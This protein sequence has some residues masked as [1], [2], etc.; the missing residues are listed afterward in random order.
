MRHT[1]LEHTC[2]AEPVQLLSPGVHLTTTL[3]ALVE[4]PGS[5][6]RTST[7]FVPTRV[8]A[9][10]LP[11]IA[12]GADDDLS[13][14]NAADEKPSVRSLPLAGVTATCNSSAQDVYSLQRGLPP[15]AAGSWFATPWGP[16]PLSFRQR[17]STTTIHDPI[18]IHPI[19][20][21]VPYILRH[22]AGFTPFW[23]AADTSVT[24]RSPSPIATGAAATR[25]G[26]QLV[27]RHLEAGTLEDRA[28]PWT[29]LDAM[30]AK[31]QTALRDPDPKS[32]TQR[33]SKRTSSAPRAM[34]PATFWQNQLVTRVAHSLL[35][36]A[37][38]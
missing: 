15:A 8:R 28:P 32:P 18:P 29:L 7:T 14:A 31:W 23:A 21:G 36:G 3:G 16:L 17:L 11:A 34:W 27:R 10:R 26:P 4:L 12:R 5:A 2:L 1:S 35:L 22:S 13:A 20:D 30:M 33:R 19:D 37:V 6:Y 9:V 24:G 38:A 25:S